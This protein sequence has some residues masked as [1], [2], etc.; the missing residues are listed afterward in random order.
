MPP[1][2]SWRNLL[3]GLIALGSIGLVAVGVLLFAGIG[4][5][6][7]DTVRLYVLTDQARG[8]MPG[9]EVWLH[10]QKV[11]VVADVDFR[12]PGP[13]T[14]ARLVIAIDIAARDARFIRRDAPVR[15]RPGAN[16][17]GPVVV[18]LATGD[19]RGAALRPGDT[20]R[21]AA[22]PDVQAAGAQLSSAFDLVPGLL[23]DGR[24]VV[25]SIREGRGTLGALVSGEAG[26]DV[27]RVRATLNRMASG[28]ALGDAR[29]VM[30]QA[31]GALARVDSIRTLLRGDRGAL[32]RFRRDSTL[33]QSIA[34][35]RDELTA[36][37]ALLA[38]DDGTLQ[39]W[40]R[41]STLV[42][43]LTGAQ[44]DM[45]RLFEDVRRRPTRYLHF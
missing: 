11:G 12:P 20:L 23:A 7:G 28:H 9:T 39:R 26:D 41:D 25:S 2:L 17:V 45:A 16:V 29:G 5:V 33:L 36:A 38:R 24:T 21:A 32:G 22:Q 4:K 31:R 1:R 18:Y 43:S 19:P 42:R 3:P 15:V 44:R 35:V 8:V 13:D 14:T 10:G 30:H 34:A 6:R 27:S 37:R 40:R